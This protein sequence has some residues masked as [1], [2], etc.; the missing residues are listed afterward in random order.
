MNGLR[1]VFVVLWVTMRVTSSPLV[2]TVQYI[3]IQFILIHTIFYTGCSRVFRTNSDND[4]MS[5]TG[6]DKLFRSQ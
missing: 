1:R 5:V 4:S 3:I 2:E 6:V